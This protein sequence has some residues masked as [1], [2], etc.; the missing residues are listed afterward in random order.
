M[1][2]L[3]DPEARAQWLREVVAMRQAEAVKAIGELSR[4][5]DPVEGLHNARFRVQALYGAVVDMR[6][7]RRRKAAQDG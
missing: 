4:G 7:A 3:Y 2:K 1:P 6:T 5:A